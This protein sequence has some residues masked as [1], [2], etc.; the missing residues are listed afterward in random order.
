[1]EVKELHSPIKRVVLDRGFADVLKLQPKP[2]ERK[3]T[4]TVV[5]YKSMSEK[6][7]NVD[8]ALYGCYE[9]VEFSPESI[10]KTFVASIRMYLLEKLWS[11]TFIQAIR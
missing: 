9:F 4:A 11:L 7:Y 5:N 6:R 2:S 3:I 10:T 8:R 1:M